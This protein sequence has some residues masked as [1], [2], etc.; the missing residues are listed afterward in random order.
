[1]HWVCIWKR[2]CIYE[3]DYFPDIS[4]EIDLKVLYENRG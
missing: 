3:K 4:P 2:T 1:M